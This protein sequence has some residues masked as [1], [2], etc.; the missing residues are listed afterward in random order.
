MVKNLQ[1]SFGYRTVAENEKTSL[2]KNVFEEVASRYDLMNDLMS[3]GVHRLWKHE[4]IKMIRPRENMHLLDLAGGTGDIACRFLKATQEFKGCSATVVDINHA[5]ILQGESRAID[6]GIIN[7]L[8]WIV[9]DGALLPFKDQ[10]FDTCTISFG[11]RNVTYIEE[12]LKEILRILK[13]GGFFFCLE[14]SKV[15]SKILDKF[16]RFYSFEVIPRIGEMVANNKSAYQYLVES[17]DR[18]YTQDELKLLM[19]TTGYQNVAYQ[20]LS[21]GVAAIH[22]GQKLI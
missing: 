20:N 3:F 15:S 16:Y 22:S 11:L 18:F 19:T 13:P 2:V 21:G 1:K 10:S 8:T 12:A 5:M 6:Q 14:F 7:G 17:I 9:A 4:L